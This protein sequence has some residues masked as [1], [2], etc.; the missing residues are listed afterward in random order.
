[1]DGNNIPLEL[2]GR[3]IFDDKNQ[4]NYAIGAFT[5]LTERVQREKA[6]RQRETAEAVNKVM[7]DS[8]QYAKIIQT[9]LLPNIAD[10]K[11]YLSNS[12][13][14]WLPRD[15][16]GGDIIYMDSFKE[17]FLLAVIDCTGHGVPGAFMTMVASTSLRRITQDEKCY[18]PANILKRL[19]FMVKTSLQQDR[20]DA[21]SDDGL[22]AAICWIKSKEKTLSFAGAKLP[23]YYIKEDKLNIITG[24]KHSLGYKSSNLEFEFSTHTI[25]I[26]TGMSFY[27]S[28]DGFVD[29]LGGDKRLP[30][31]NKRFR[32][33]LKEIQRL[34][35]DEQ[36]KKIMQ[37]FKEYKGDNDR[38]DDVT[39]VGFGF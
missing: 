15:I 22:D 12:F 20:E 34:S 6:E 28:T 26:E 36:S 13:F 32:A 9:S 5:D 11:T 14:L 27:L 1:M 18:E 38:Q 21:H 17:G 19:N 4:V 35:F 37:A 7:M 2:W 31:G 10:V 3:P 39:V 23:L 25:K 16:V 29:Q 33:L 30:F 8:I 24:D